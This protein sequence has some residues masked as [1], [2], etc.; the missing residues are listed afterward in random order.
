MW[1]SIVQASVKL[2]GLRAS[3]ASYSFRLPTNHVHVL[4]VK[5]TEFR[6]DDVSAGKAIAVEEQTQV[7]TSECGEGVFDRKASD[8]AKASRST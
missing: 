1:P 6:L 8:K 3:D 2:V 5:T 4:E 7:L